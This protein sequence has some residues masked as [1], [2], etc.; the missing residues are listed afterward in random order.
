MAN[1]DQSIFDKAKHALGDVTDKITGRDDAT[2]GDSL[3]DKAKGVA[4]D[5]RDKVSEIV[6]KH[7]GKIDSAVDKTADFVDDKTGGKFSDRIG[8]A[9]DA[10]H[11]AVD[12]LGGGDAGK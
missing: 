4:G 12:K 11:G 6:D 9:K 8:K 1:D 5:L 10:A 7:D 2:K 3:L